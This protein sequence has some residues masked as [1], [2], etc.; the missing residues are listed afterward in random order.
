MKLLLR[1]YEQAFTNCT[2]M[3]KTGAPVRIRGFTFPEGARM[4]ANTEL[5]T[6]EVTFV[7]EDLRNG[8]H[9]AVRQTELQFLEAPKQYGWAEYGDHCLYVSLTSLRQWRKGLTS[10]RINCLR[11]YPN[12]IKETGELRMVRSSRRMELDARLMTGIFGAP[13]RP[14]GKAVGV[15]M[16]RRK[17]SETKA[18]ARINSNHA[19]MAVNPDGPFI[20]MLE[21]T[22]VGVY[23]HDKN[24]LVVHPDNDCFVEQLGSVY[25]NIIFSENLEKVYER[26]G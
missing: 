2:T 22:A 24:T 15:A 4:G 17:N 19:I 18:C 21:D 5:D 11:V 12:V 1:D 23:L 7:V 16:T 14:L 10:R 26:I 9:H 6:T 3:L 20:A 13:E 8:D 25:D